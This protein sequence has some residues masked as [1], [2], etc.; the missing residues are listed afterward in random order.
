MF[1]N[2]VITA[3]RNLVRNRLY[4]VINVVGLAVGF[5][6]ALLIALFVR[7]ELTF[8]KWIPA[9]KNVY[10]ISA[11]NPG[12][13]PAA[14]GPSDVAIWLKLEFPQVAAVTRLLSS[15][16]TLRHNDREFSETITWA[17]PN[18]FDVLKF[19]IVAGDSK[20][21][22][23]LPD[24][25]V[26]TRKIARKY[27]GRDDP[28]G[29]TLELNRTHPMKITAIIDDPPSNTNLAI[30]VI[31]AGQTGYSDLASQDA[32][33][34]V[35]FGQKVWSSSTYFTLRAGTTIDEV[36]RHLPAMLDRRAPSVDG[37][38]MSQ[39]YTLSVMSLADI[40]LGIPDPPAVRPPGTLEFIQSSIA[41]GVLVL[42]AA[43]TNFI[44]LMT[45]RAARRA[46]EVGVRKV[47]GA[48]RLNLIIQ[49]IG[50]SL[51]YVFLG[52]AM[53]IILVEAV[54]PAFNAFL[55][56]TIAFDFW[57]DSGFTSAILISTALI[58]ILAGSYPAFVLAEYSPSSV[59]KSGAVATGSF[60]RV[61]QTLV[62]T[63]FAILIGL[64]IATAAF[65]Q[66]TLF[67]MRQSLRQ[68][69]DQIVQLYNTTCTDALRNSILS[70]PGVHDVACSWQVPQFGIY[71]GSGAQRKDGTSSVLY[72]T[73]LD[74]GYLELYGYRP[75][76]GRFFV[77]DRDRY[78]ESIGSTRPEAIV[79]NESAVRSLGFES[80][81]SAIGQVISWMHIFKIPS[82]FTPFHDAEIIG[83]V[84][85]F[86]MG[87]VRT[88]VPAAAFYVNPTQFRILHAKVDGG[89]LP[90]VMAA[91]DGVW[92]KVGD[93][94][95]IQ[96]SLYDV[97]VQRV[98]SDITRQ[99]RLFGTFSAIAIF[100]AALGL[101]GLA[102]FTAENRTKEIGIR[103]AMG[104]SKSDILRLLLWQFAKPVLWANLIAWPVAGYLMNRWLHGFAYHVDLDPL[105]FV[106][107]SAAA[108]LIALATVAGH[109]LLVA[110]AKPVAALRYE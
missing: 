49:F 76:A 90:E 14:T 108:L 69:A 102:S 70:I 101:F 50:E 20:S 44:N 63:Q 99:S 75:I 31:A 98:Y 47:T 68:N 39:Y 57:R 52:L 66:Q 38:K 71:T 15:P 51:I 81:E 109:A 13:P 58:G 17:D 91:I 23:T 103:K 88:D 22:I 73:C 41:V 8:D 62:I 29:E 84:P 35:H 36:K 60:G 40:H 106:G 11:G 3:L 10:R 55:S 79:V 97:G 54:L 33:P 7:D 25:I 56:R 65:Y 46:V 37:Q 30:D 83:V 6:A 61:R 48:T 67:A 77:R 18:V 34:M 2:Y 53:A 59:L 100:I 24:T 43:S 9:Y 27:F 32:Y 82:T 86:P 74:F 28:V 26:V 19:P 110:R 94:H 42:F 12:K 16:G 1:R 95:P 5:A 92:K 96:R 72:H 104:A 87:S 78:S 45:A 93:S 89:A 4:A 85:N 64:T 80:P 21:A 107:A 105:I